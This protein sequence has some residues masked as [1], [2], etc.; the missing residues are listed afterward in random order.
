[1]SSSSASA[2]PSLASRIGLWLGPL[3]LILTWL[4]PAPAGMTDPAW[5][6]VGLALL[7]ATWWSTEAIPIPATS[8][9]P[10]V[11]VPALGIEGMSDTAVSYA[12]PIIYLFLGGFLLGIAMQRWDL[13]RRIALHVLKV[14][15]QRPRRQ[16]GGF[17][18]A[19]GFL[20]MW[21]SNTATAIMMLP[22][23][24]SV[25]SLLDDSDPE[26][27]RRYAT[28]LLLAIA[29]S[30]SIGGVATLIGTPPNALLAGYLA[31]SRGIDLGFA[32]W[33]L[34]GLPISLAMMVCAWWWLTRRGFALETSQDGA[35]MVDR[36]LAKLGAMSSAER[37]VGLIFL[38]AALAWIVRPLL[39]QHGLDWLSDTGIAIAAGILLF[40]LP[41]GN[42]QG[43]R[44]MHWEDAQGLP[45]GILLLFGG[46]LAL[47]GA[48]S[49]SGLAEWIAERLGV[50]GVFPILALIGVVVLVIIFLTEVTSNTATAAAFLPLLG[51]LALSL[52]ISPLLITVPAA[53]A[54]S[55]AF[56]MP[57]ATPPNAIVFATGHMKIQ[58]MIRAGFVLNLAG[59]VLVT[60]LAYPL[61]KLF[62]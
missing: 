12:N 51:A 2:P 30:A 23:G 27:L 62:W 34:V 17:M 54:A 11:L 58:S 56:M 41:S 25:V 6:C 46:G 21:V 37:R 7:M 55:C 19:T 59:T 38:L 22:I 48:I 35:A 16:I 43:R 29:Y 32:Q 10:L 18:I 31:D 49:R 40:L 47:A 1:M 57:V 14:V 44:L 5:A 4:L 26:E 24:M 20:S 9:L 52:D 39:N 60:L 15:G 42:E 45:W 53:I 13:H 28:A 61:L 33:M 3:W 50:F 36:E 8:L